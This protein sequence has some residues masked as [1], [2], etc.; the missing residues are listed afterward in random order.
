MVFGRR[1][2]AQ[3]AHTR[4][5]H[6]VGRHHAGE[7]RELC[8]PAL[9]GQVRAVNQGPAAAG[10]RHLLLG[11][12]QADAAASHLGLLAQLPDHLEQVEHV[13][14]LAAVDQGLNLVVA[15]AAAA[16][17]PGA[18]HGGVDHGAV[19]VQLDLPDQGRTHH[20]GQQAGPVLAEHLGVQRRAP[21]RRVQRL[22]P[23]VALV[24]DH[25]A[26]LDERRHVRDRVA[27][28]VARVGAR[29]V[30]R[31]VEIERPGRVDGDELDVGEVG[32]R[33]LDVGGRGLGRLNHLDR[34]VV[35]HAQLVAQLPQPLTQRRGHLVEK[36]DGTTRHR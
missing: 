11:H 24:I 20:V 12:A 31:L 17:H 9:A 34:K 1:Q 30:Q 2:G 32:H 15:V 26:G 33:Q 18:C 8:I 7:Q 29:Q 36:G 28:Q 4:L 35:G 22:D 23:L 3:N 25:P 6:H 10:D 14:G 19:G 21:A 13:A 5:Q 27:H 16:A